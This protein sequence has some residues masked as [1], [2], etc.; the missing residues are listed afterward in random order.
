MMVA[1]KEAPGC[2]AHSPALSFTLSAFLGPGSP[3]APALPACVKHQ[4]KACR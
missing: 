1:L 3:L 2:E 4:Q